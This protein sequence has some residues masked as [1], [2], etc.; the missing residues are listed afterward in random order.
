MEFRLGSGTNIIGRN[1]TCE[2]RLEDPLASRQHARLNITDHIQ[3]ID[4]GSANGVELNG[5]VIAREVVR[6]SDVIQIGDT[7][8]S[9]R[10]VQVESAAGRTEGSVGF[11][12]SP[13]L[14]P[15]YSGREFSPPEPPQRSQR[16]PFP[17]SML[18][19]PILMA[20]VLYLVTKQWQTLIFAGLSPLMM[21]GSWWEQRRHGRTA[22]KNASS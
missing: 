3:I 10:M 14:A 15:R 17:V 5:S 6:P 20:G 8:L 16:Q 4:L 1:R 11:I 2:I 18:V 19:M 7:R 9:V 21:I 22:D 12:R 13:R